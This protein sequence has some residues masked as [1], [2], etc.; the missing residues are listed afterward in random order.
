M[1]VLREVFSHSLDPGAG[2]MGMHCLRR[3]LPRASLP[4]VIQDGTRCCRLASAAP[5]L[6]TAPRLQWPKPDLQGIA[7]IC[8]AKLA[9]IFP[10]RPGDFL[11]H[12]LPCR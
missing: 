4:D 9:D 1:S 6:L 5:R 11:H 7:L 3:R 12:G 2:I 10:Q 8:F